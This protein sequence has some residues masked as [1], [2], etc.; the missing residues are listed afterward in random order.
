MFT[1]LKSGIFSLMAVSTIV[2]G[3]LFCFTVT[4]KA[5]ENPTIYICN[6]PGGCLC[7]Y[8]TLKPGGRCLCG[9]I[10]IPSDRGPG[11]DL[12]YECDC[13]SGCDCGTQADEQDNCHCGVLMREIE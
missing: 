1:C 3:T 4:S 5:A 12:E 8:E 2:L 7:E 6:C 10:T 9:L 11:E 13:D